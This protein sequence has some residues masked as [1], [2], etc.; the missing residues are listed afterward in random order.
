MND[1]DLVQTK[2]P[3]EIRNLFSS[4]AHRYD[5]ANSTLSVGIHHLWRKALV[6]SVHL[7]QDAKVLD[8]A[9]GTGDVAFAW[10]R[11]LS[12]KAKIIGTDFCE[13]MLELA[14]KKAAQR[15]STVH[16]EFA[17]ICKLPFASQQFDAASVSFGIRNVVDPALGLRELARVTKRG[18]KVLILEF[19]QP[20]RALL[21]GMYQWYS[22]KLLPVLGGWV[23]GKRQ[24]YAYLEKS[25]SAFPYGEAFLNLARAQGCFA[26]VQSQALT[27]GIAYLYILSVA[28]Q[29]K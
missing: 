28:D 3:S 10:E 16:F 15:D 7:P 25:S 18:G 26:E 13:P 11:S 12:S 1:Q 6:S 8:C 19:G 29:S 24:A 23:S 5:L 21:R 20:K 9:T 17:D 22:R 4:I 2:N 14:K 27:G